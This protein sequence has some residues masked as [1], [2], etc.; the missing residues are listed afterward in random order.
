MHNCQGQ[1]TPFDWSTSAIRQPADVAAGSTVTLLMP[2]AA[3]T[4]RPWRTAEQLPGRWVDAVDLVPGDVLLL[5]NGREAVVTTVEWQDEPETVYNFRVAELSCYAVGDCGALVHNSCRRFRNSVHSKTYG[6]HP[7]NTEAAHI[8]PNSNWKNS[9][10]ISNDAKR[11]IQTAKEKINKYL[12]SVQ[13]NYRNGF[14]TNDRRHLGTHTD[15]YFIRLGREFSRV[16]S[17]TDV[18]RALNRMRALIDAGT[19]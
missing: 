11:G 7:A 18:L 13:R 8:A 3:G 17:G 9:N 5:R 4:N 6:P 19:F 10:N 16:N 15:A 14:L 2:A 12:P 1:L